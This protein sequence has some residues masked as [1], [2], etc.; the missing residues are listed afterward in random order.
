MRRFCV[1]LSSLK[2][3]K[4]R[5]REERLL[6]ERISDAGTRLELSSICPLAQNASC[7]LLG[8]LALPFTRCPGALTP[9][10]SNTRV[11]FRLA[12]QAGQQSHGVSQGFKLDVRV[13]LMNVQR[14]TTEWINPRRIISNSVVRLKP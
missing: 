7:G 2:N 6:L 4:T 13:A 8:P 12:R 9:H 10:L 5:W 11:P 3:L 1:R 14:I